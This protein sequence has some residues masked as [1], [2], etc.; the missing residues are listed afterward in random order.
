[1]VV[2]TRTCP[3][4]LAER[5]T[6]RLLDAAQMGPNQ[7]V[8]VFVCQG[9]QRILC[10][11]Y[12]ASRWDWVEQ[13]IGNFD[14]GK[15]DFNVT[16]IQSYPSPPQPSCPEDVPN[17]VRR[18]FLQGQDNARRGQFDAAAAMYRKAL[19]L[20]TQAL[21]ESLAPKRLQSRIDALHAAGRLTEALKDWAHLV[22]IDGNQGAHGDEE[23]TKA[24]IDQLGSFCELFLTY[25]FTLPV[26]VSQRKSQAEAQAAG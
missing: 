11:E 8:A 2:L 12:Y 23:F 10:V 5:M 13:R 9:C 24:E 3:H 21:D 17:G 18:S 19:D 4:C 7:G 1:M 22:R 6:F 16:E 15:A 26:Q 20:A 25:T 14:D